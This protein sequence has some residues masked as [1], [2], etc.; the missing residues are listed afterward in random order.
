M[1]DTVA[2]SSVDR[3]HRSIV[4]DNRRLDPAA[5]AAAASSMRVVVDDDVAPVRPAGAGVAG[6]ATAVDAAAAER[7]VQERNQARHD[8]DQRE[9]GTCEDEDE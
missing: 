7:R 8:P 9:W 3:M 6:V 1:R 4:V 2:P 5:V